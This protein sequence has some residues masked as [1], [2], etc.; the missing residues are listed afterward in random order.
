MADYSSTTDRRVP[1]SVARNRKPSTPFSVVTS[2]PV[3]S[4]KKSTARNVPPLDLSNMADSVKS[5]PSPS[6]AITSHRGSDR[7]ITISTP[8]NKR[9][10]KRANFFP[11]K[12]EDC[13]IGSSPDEPCNTQDTL[14]EISI[15]Q[16]NSNSKSRADIG[17]K[18]SAPCT[19]IDKRNVKFDDRPVVNDGEVTNN[20][21]ASRNNSNLTRP[22]DLTSRA[23]RKF[24]FSSSSKEKQKPFWSPDSAPKSLPSQIKSDSGISMAAASPKSFGTSHACTAEKSGDNLRRKELSSRSGTRKDAASR[25]TSV[26]DRMKSKYFTPKQLNLDKRS[27]FYSP[28]STFSSRPSD[29]APALKSSPYNHDWRKKIKSE[30]DRKRLNMRQTRETIR[31]LLTELSNLHPDHTEDASEPTGGKHRP[32]RNSKSLPST[33]A[34]ILPSNAHGTR[35]KRTVST[36]TA[37][38][39]WKNT[40]YPNNKVNR[41]KNISSFVVLDDM[42]VDAYNI[43]HSYLQDVQAAFLQQGQAHDNED[44]F[45]YEPKAD[46]KALTSCIKGGDLNRSTQHRDFNSCVTFVDCHPEST[47]ACHLLSDFPEDDKGK[48]EDVEYIDYREKSHDEEV[49]YIDGQRLPNYAN[50]GYY[51]NVGTFPHT[52]GGMGRNGLRST[53]PPNGRGL[54]SKYHHRPMTFGTAPRG[55]YSH[56]TH[57]DNSPMKPKVVTVVR[58]GQTRPHKK[59]TILL[60]RRAV[61]TY[62]QLVADISEALGQPKWKNDHIRKLYTLKGR[63][64]RSVS[65]FFREDD[66]FIAV[67]REQLTTMD[68]QEVLQ[69]LY[70]DS[71]YAENLIRLNLQ[72]SSKLNKQSRKNHPEPSK[73][74]KSDS[75][76]GESTEGERA[77]GRFTSD[78]PHRSPRNEKT[79]N[80]QFVDQR[81]KEQERMK[82]NKWER[83]RWEREQEEL[84]EELRRRHGNRNHDDEIDQSLREAE[85]RKKE[86][87]QWEAEEKERQKRKQ[88]EEEER[89]R[90]EEDERRERERLRK[91]ALNHVNRKERES[92]EQRR[93]KQLE[94]ELK[95]ERQKEENERKRRMR[96]EEE[97]RRRKEEEEE[98][99]RREELEKERKRLEEERRKLEE[100]KKRLR[101]EEERRLRE[102]RRMR[103]EQDRLERLERERREKEREEEEKRRKRET[104]EE[105]KRRKEAQQKRNKRP[106]SPPTSVTYVNNKADD[107]DRFRRMQKFKAP[108]RRIITRQDI[109][110]RYEIGKTI[111][112]GNFAVVKE[113][114]LRNTESEYAMK[115]IDKSKLKGKEDMIENEIAIMKNCHHPNIVRL[116]EEFETDDEIYLVLEYVKGGD[117]F[118]AITESVKFTERDAA[119]M[120]ADLSE[121]LAFLHSKNIIHRDLKPENLL[122]SRNKDGS[123]T[124]KLADFGLAMEVT[125]P[126]YTVCGTPTYV[127][128]EILAESGYGLEVDMWATG[129][130]TYILL[131]GFP[132]FRSL[133][134][135]QE[136]LF[137]IIQLGDYEFLSPYWDNISDAAKDLIQRLLVVD[138]KRR[139]TAEQVL[140]HPWIQSEGS[141]KGPNLQREITMNLE[142]NFGDRTRRKAGL[143]AVH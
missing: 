53:F 99:K 15:D 129:V 135:D 81:F 6:R 12:S 94:D 119:N 59:I 122:V 91:C 69:E 52:S 21:T 127:A 23:N 67:G 44:L 86:R 62:E 113:C 107:T 28:S 137:E 25:S 71:P 82:A 13:G 140:A 3:P 60:N 118:D 2:P 90:R 10:A 92:E 30:E 114:R 76:L 64:V 58:A 11:S 110:S 75:G 126:I 70:P 51:D 20:E 42:E 102:E 32:L 101:E 48:V 79:R 19:I 111:G 35:R 24:L 109:E 80:R 56:S 78:P 83:V 57:S 128:P 66:V 143:Q 43:T 123:M 49:E 1:N 8:A 46:G 138:T 116:I 40:K 72:K 26:E 68:V 88:L 141:Y 74:S 130:I 87:L 77:G 121:A 33:A 27:K 103:D 112:D 73:A 85:R 36:S 5:E 29:L 54:A 100:E 124:L 63:E 108:P 98:R 18:T 41:R 65:D 34:N 84:D 89:R 37:P 39:K 104:E 120:V 96:E 22:N 95:R 132:P 4:A 134:R 14:K 136:E 16:T 93:I 115:I 133:E 131:C 50:G 117:L 9:S 125:E 38:S 139:F 97:R 31:L 106:H 17:N 45:I 55:D 7:R 142:K 61:Q 105:E 47:G